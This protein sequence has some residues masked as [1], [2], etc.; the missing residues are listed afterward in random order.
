MSRALRKTSRVMGRDIIF[1]ADFPLKLAAAGES[2]TPICR[3][4]TGDTNYP[5][6]QKQAEAVENL[7]FHTD[8]DFSKTD[9]YFAAAKVFVNTSDAEGFANTFIQATKA[10]TPILTWQVNPDQFLTQYQCG[11][12]CGGDM[13]KLAQGLSFLLENRR[14]QEL[15]QNGQRYVQEHH[16]ITKITERYKQVFREILQTS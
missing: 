9:A 13:D 3:P 10:A 5:Q 12:A 14:Y 2:I 4:A 15:G 7:E 1:A 8:V 11:L 16:D 6:L